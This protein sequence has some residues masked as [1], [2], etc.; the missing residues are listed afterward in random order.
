MF[1]HQ[2]K[3]KNTEITQH[4]SFLFVCVSIFVCLVR[5]SVLIFCMHAQQQV[6][7]GMLGKYTGNSIETLRYQECPAT[8]HVIFIVTKS[9][10]TWSKSRN[11][12]NNSNKSV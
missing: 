12:N 6:L 9:L 7:E 2:K 1:R 5:N 8:F 3:Q 4:V 11:D 10:I